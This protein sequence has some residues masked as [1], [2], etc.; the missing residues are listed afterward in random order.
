MNNSLLNDNLVKDEI[1]KEIK[2]ILEF[3]E[4]EGISYQNLWEIMNVVLRQNSK[5]Y[6]SPKRNRREHIGVA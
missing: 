3:N 5:L 1:K 2:D 6:V 4:N